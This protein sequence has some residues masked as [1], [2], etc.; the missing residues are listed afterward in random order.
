MNNYYAKRKQLE[1]EMGV[2]DFA[3]I[4]VEWGGL[5]PRTKDK[6]Q[7]KG[8]ITK[9]GIRSLGFCLWLG[10]FALVQQKSSSNWQQSLQ[11]IYS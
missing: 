9:G 8:L 11:I 10:Q 4:M 7:A 3:A 5:F 2:R 6:R 1:K